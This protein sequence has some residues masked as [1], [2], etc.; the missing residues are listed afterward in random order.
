MYTEN[1]PVFCVH[2]SRIRSLA[3]EYLCI[4]V[5]VSGSHGA[6]GD[7]SVPKGEEL[8]GRDPT[9]ARGGD[10]GQAEGSQGCGRPEGDQAESHG[11]GNAGTGRSRWAVL[12]RNKSVEASLALSVRME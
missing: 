12:K 4:R 7:R 5:P 8:Q 3:N 1:V 11:A 10:D 9:H 6:D 2:C